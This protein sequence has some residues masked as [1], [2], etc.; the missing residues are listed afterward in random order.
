VKTANINSVNEIPLLEMDQVQLVKIYAQK[1]TLLTK[2]QRV[3]FDLL[4]NGMLIKNIA[5]HL[6]FAEITV[7]VEKA[8]IMVLLGADTL[9]ELVV[10][11]KC[12]SCNY[13]KQHF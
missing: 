1:L 10:I 11:G 2:R 4:S 8:R 7:K 9:Q 12:N 5:K 6:G 3:I 13:V